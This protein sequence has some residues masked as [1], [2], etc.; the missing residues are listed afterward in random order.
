MRLLLTSDS[1]YIF[2]PERQ[3]KTSKLFPLKEY[4]DE[5]TK[6][7]NKEIENEYK[8]NLFIFFSH[9]FFL[10]KDLG[11]IGNNLVTR[12]VFLEGVRVRERE[13]GRPLSFLIQR[14]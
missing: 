3:K 14:Q 8:K 7:K 9:F 11:A 6:H 13:R 5:Q 10:N 1:F 2:F 4:T 12:P